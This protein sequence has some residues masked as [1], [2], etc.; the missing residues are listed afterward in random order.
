[1]ASQLLVKLGAGD[2]ESSTCSTAQGAMP[3]TDV[4]QELARVRAEKVLEAAKSAELLVVVAAQEAE[5]MQLRAGLTPSEAVP[6]GVA[7]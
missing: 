2:V 4:R 6:P 7:S 1:M 5:L 3:I